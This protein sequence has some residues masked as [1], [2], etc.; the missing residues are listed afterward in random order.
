VNPW[1]SSKRSGSRLLKQI[2][3]CY[4]LLHSRDQRVW[5]ISA[6]LQFLLSVLDLFGVILIGIIGALSVRGLQNAEYGDRIDLVLRFLRLDNQD[7]RF[8]VTSLGALAVGFF[9]VKTTGSA[10][11]QRKVIRF[12]SSRTAHFSS[13]IFAKS[14]KEL[15]IKS[16]NS[17]M[18]Q[19]IYAVT[20]G[21]SSIMNGVLVQTLN[22]IS[23]SSLFL[24]L[25][26]GLFLVEPGIALTTLTVFSLTA[27]ILSKVMLGRAFVIGKEMARQ[28]TISSQVAE[29]TIRMFREY[30]VSDLIE[31]ALGRFRSSRISF[32]K[33]ESEQRFAPYISKYAFEIVMILSFAVVTGIQF[34]INSVATSAGNIS[35]FLAASVRIAPAVLRLQQS[36][37]S[38]KGNL[39]GASPTF[40]LLEELNTLKPRANKE[41]THAYASLE[42][43]NSQFKHARGEVISMNS[44][45]FAY[46]D[47]KS[48]TLVKLNLNLREGEH[49]AI[50]GPSGVGK[51]TLVDLILGIRK[52]TSGEILLFGQEPEFVISHRKKV[53]SYVPQKTW[54]I[55]AT[56]AE[57]VRLTS[58]EP[59]S[60]TDSH[61][62]DLFQVVGLHIENQ[63]T[64]LLDY[65]VGYG[66]SKLSGGQSQRIAIARALA[67]NPNL[68]ILDEATNALDQNSQELILKRIMSKYP[69]LTLITITHNKSLLKFADTIFLLG[70]KKFQR[71][72]SFNEFRRQQAK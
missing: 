49:L 65:R 51:T 30:Y 20:T 1:I 53:L 4:R 5:W 35:V 48:E 31:S 69:R 15:G 54:L 52:P 43:I 36:L 33:V 50:F 41:A 56:I 70:K 26:F 11:V 6:C 9:V 14:I 67:R 29:E 10:L 3:Y 22:L 13:Q 32:S 34:S 27:L 71:F 25:L 17:D 7:L 16:T 64:D 62:L 46:G 45:S 57:N 47:S 37:I 40:T 8:Q 72:S 18:Q 44:C 68:L 42:S 39:G 66:G 38:L 58:T 23:D 12:F 21:V 61:I 60:V 28:Q 55:D 2:R 24:I 59:S 63:D 19:Q